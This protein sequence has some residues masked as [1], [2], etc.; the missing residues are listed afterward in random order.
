MRGTQM[1][2]VIVTDN[3]VPQI[4]GF[5]RT[6]TAILDILRAQGDVIEVI[7]PGMF[8]SVP[9]P[10]YPEIRLCVGVGRKLASQ[11][12]RSSPDAIHVALEGPLGLAARGYCVSRGIPFTTSF[13]TK[14]PE[15]IERR[16]RLPVSISYRWLRWFHS[17]AVRCMVATT[18]LAEELRGRG[19]TNLVPWTRGVDVDLFRPHDKSWLDVPRP[20]WLYV[21]RVAVE[22]NIGAFLD[23]SLPGTKVVV[24]DGPQRESLQR[25]YPG[26]LFAGAHTGTMLARHYAAADVLVFPSLTDTFGLVI[27][28]ALAC[29]V[30]VAAYPVTGPRD[31]IGTSSV[32]VMDRDLATAA[33]R[34]LGISPAVCRAFAQSFSW[35]LPARQFRGYMPPIHGA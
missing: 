29:G 30:P 34:A 2:I 23:L 28:E 1:K 3:W 17:A 22:K 18:S 33:K 32:G 15:Y 6:Y 5:V 4:S 8:R 14:W 21:G 10:T 11:L 25:K 13:T 31:V 26:V 12:D 24:G 27:L 20:V 9:C 19:F 7:H 35:S 16:V